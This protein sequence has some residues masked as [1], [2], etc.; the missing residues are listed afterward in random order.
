MSVPSWVWGSGG[1]LVV[2]AAARALPPPVPNGNEFYLWFYNFVGLLLANFDKIGS[3]PLVSTSTGQP[4][5]LPPFAPGTK[6][7]QK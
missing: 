2:S 5:S 4:G 3:P 7:D 6:E 1:A